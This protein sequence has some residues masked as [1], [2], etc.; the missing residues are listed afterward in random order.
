MTLYGRI[1]ALKNVSFQIRK[2]E[3]F[4]LVGETGCGKTVTSLALLGLLPSNARSRG[5]I[6]FEQEQLTAQNV[7]QKRG[8]DIAVVFQDPM[9]SLNPL[10]TVRQQLA[11][12]LIA[13][14]RV[15]KK[16]A[17]RSVVDI[18][19]EVQML[20]ANRVADLYPH[21]LSGGMKQRVMIAMALSCRP[22]LLIADEPTTALDVTIQKQ[23]LWLMKS[24]REKHGFSILFIT[25]D[26]GVVAEFAHRVGVMYAGS[27]VEIATKR[28]LFKNPLHPYTVGLLNA[29]PNSRVGGKLKAIPG[30]VP[31]LVN[32][33]TGCRF[34]ER[35]ERAF[36]KCFREIPP[37]IEVEDQHYVACHVYG[38]DEN[39]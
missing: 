14:R 39:G 1:K 19:R 4:S 15:P 37:L 38:G 36:K 9:T 33:P 23:I 24:L 7:E 5:K 34:N 8:R 12:V 11:D 35:C 25:H 13:R 22:K 29:V 18:L 28:R 20:D 21:E 2:N 6:F 17:L 16:E 32:P 27:I 26:M 30:S 10:Y 3:V 31:S